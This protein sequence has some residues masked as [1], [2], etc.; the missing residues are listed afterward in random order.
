MNMNLHL[1]PILPITNGPGRWTLFGWKTMTGTSYTVHAI[2]LCEHQK[3]RA[4]S[5]W[6]VLIPFHKP[7]FFIIETYIQITIQYAQCQSISTLSRYIVRLCKRYFKNYNNN[8]TM[9]PIEYKLERM[10]HCGLEKINLKCLAWLQNFHI[11]LSDG[12]ILIGF[13][14]I[15]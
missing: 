3:S 1:L 5:Q 9:R 6:N 13:W 4:N 15:T 11:S 14:A 7:L 2:N 10:N 12:L 8:K